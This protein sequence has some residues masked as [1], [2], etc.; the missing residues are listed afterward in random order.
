MLDRLRESSR[1]MVIYVL[2][3]IV[4]AV[5]IINFGPHSGGCDGPSAM[6]PSMAA[7]VDGDTVTAKDF[8]YGYILI[9]GP[10]YPPQ[11]AKDLRIKERVMDELID[12]ELLVQEAERLGFRVSESEAEDF[13]LSSKIVGPGGYEQSMTAVQKDG[14]F[15]YDTFAKFV[16]Y[17]LGMQPKAFLEQQRKELLA[18]RVRNVVRGGV[19]VSLDEVKTDFERRNNQVNLEYVR[20]SWRRYED[21]VDVTPEEAE[22]YAKANEKKL[23]ELY[24]QRKFLYENAPKERRLRQIQVKLDSGAT[25]DATKVIEKKAQALADRIKKGEAFAAVAKAASDDA[26]SKRKGGLLGWRRQ[27]STTLGAAIEEKV[28]AAKDGELVGPI[29]G[30]DGFY[31]VL[32][33]ATRE[34]TIP[35]EKV[36]SELAENELRQ[37]KSKAKAKI[38]ADAALAKAKGAKDKTLK[39]LFPAP[40]ETLAGAESAPRAEETGLFVRRG[41]VVE[42]IGTAADLA[43]AAFT[44]TTEQPFAGPFEVTSSYIIV[45]LK[46]R[47][48]ADMAEFEKKKGELLQEAQGVRGEEVLAEWTRRRCVDAKEAKK[49]QV[50]T[51]LL[52]Y[53]ESPD[54]RVTYEPCTPPFRF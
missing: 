34:G 31:L 29:K 4:I 35:F 24:D 30:T 2:F 51:E 18:A 49:I 44:L 13:V 9:G 12:R 7:N 46:E 50:N 53:D 43:K 6:R 5:F 20:Y 33:E 37:E 36:R 28:W 15:D 21:D 3:G 23:K 52:K 32:P 16:Q 39:D 54:S 17:S 38:E 19:N 41:A 26:R 10:Q 40:P 42:G 1:S 48:Q 11:R 47:K 27:G 22:T 25:A 8:R 45:R 14:H